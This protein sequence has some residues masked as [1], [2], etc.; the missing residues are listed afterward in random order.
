[1]HVWFALLAGWKAHAYSTVAVAA[2]T[3]NFPQMSVS[4]TARNPVSA[5][6]AEE[7]A[8]EKCKQRGGT[9]CKPFSV[10]RACLAVAMNDEFSTFFSATSD[11]QAGAQT[12]A[13]AKCKKESGNENCSLRTSV[14]DF[15]VCKR[16]GDYHACLRHG[17]ALFPGSAKEF[18]HSQFC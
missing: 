6:V 15:A 9:G 7:A 12:A 18:C 5:L 10:D 2:S 3:A 11:A 8:L 4:A 14:C 1:M 13:V 16:D 17:D